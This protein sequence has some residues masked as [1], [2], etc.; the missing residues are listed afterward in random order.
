MFWHVNMLWMPN[1]SVFDWTCVCVAQLKSASVLSAQFI[2]W[3]RRTTSLGCLSHFASGRTSQF[4]WNYCSLLTSA[5]FVPQHSSSPT[6][7]FSQ[8]SSS[9]L[10]WVLDILLS[11]C[12]KIMWHKFYLPSVWGHL[13]SLPYSFWVIFIFLDQSSLK[14]SADIVITSLSSTNVVLLRA[15]PRGP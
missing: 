2:R 6:S 4:P 12:V 7:P 11:H 10:L 13:R 5:L 8:S 15:L 9:L 14:I 3:V 1:D